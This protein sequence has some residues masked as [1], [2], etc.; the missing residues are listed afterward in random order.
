MRVIEKA[1]SQSGEYPKVSRLRIKGKKQKG[2]KQTHFAV[3]GRRIT[4]CE[5]FPGMIYYMLWFLRNTIPTNGGHSVGARR[6]APGPRASGPC[7]PIP[8]YG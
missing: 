6:D 8:D 3:T 1:G 4:D 7:G 5:D 2:V